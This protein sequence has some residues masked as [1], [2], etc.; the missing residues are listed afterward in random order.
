MDGTTHSDQ[1]I[2]GGDHRNIIRSLI[3]KES[4]LAFHIVRKRVIAIQVIFA[5]VEQQC[6]LGVKGIY[7][8]EL[9]AAHFNHCCFE[10]FFFSK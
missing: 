2:A 3:G 5:D 1:R 9:E 7:G 10:I 6:N 4:A 8:I